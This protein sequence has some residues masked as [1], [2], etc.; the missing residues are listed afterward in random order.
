[1]INK[2]V[3]ADSEG[4]EPHSARSAPWPATQFGIRT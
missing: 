1:L 3:P 4:Q 2:F